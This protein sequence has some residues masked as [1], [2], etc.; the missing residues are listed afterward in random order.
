MSIYGLV[1]GPI[2]KHIFRY[3][4]NSVRRRHEDYEKR[5]NTLYKSDL[6][7]RFINWYIKNKFDGK[8]RLLQIG[9][10]TYPVIV[11][12]A[13][14][15]FWDRIQR[16]VENDKE[17]VKSRERDI[18]G[19]KL[20]RKREKPFIYEVEDDARDYCEQ[21][22]SFKK[23][24]DSFGPFGVEDRAKYS[25][26]RTDL[27]T[28]KM[29]CAL[30]WYY[31]M[32]KTCEVLEYEF[33]DVLS[34]YS[35]RGIQ[36]NKFNRLFSRMIVRKAMH[37]LVPDPVVSGDYRDAV[38]GI[39]TLIA[40]LDLERNGYIFLIARRSPRVALGSSLLHVIPSSLFEPMFEEELCFN[41]KANIYREY[42]EELFDEEHLMGEQDS[43]Y[44]I[45]SDELFPEIAHLRELLHR[46]DAQLIFLGLAFDV[47]RLRPEICTL[48][49]ISDPNWRRQIADGW[50]RKRSIDNR[51][52]EEHI[53][54]N[55][56]RFSPEFLVK[57]SVTTTIQTQIEN[58]DKFLSYIKRNIEKNMANK[59]VRLD[60]AGIT[61]PGIATLYLAT[62]TIQKLYRDRE[63]KFPV[64]GVE[65]LGP[66]A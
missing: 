18:I 63:I 31:R 62:N 9:G 20:H 17:L 57:T 35:L 48:L 54:L 34:K 19:E 33:V 58:T 5:R 25:M 12:P 39:S 50:K 7:Q 51:V 3:L 53:R 26:I 56:R 6:F 36:E 40:Y 11:F 44:S 66:R 23:K 52:I 47:L 21:F 27:D 30:G 24:L 42:A 37:R 13:P 29:T 28:L 49:L 1:R 38:I 45:F 22:E 43:V 10:A 65:I 55:P 64:I 61:P 59:N 15:E 46:G 60:P 16:T 14:K 41:I 4:V 8:Y 2:S 32:V